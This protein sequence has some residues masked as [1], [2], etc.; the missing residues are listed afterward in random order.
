MYV[1]SELFVVANKAKLNC[2]LIPC[3]DW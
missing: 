1:Y 3:V 2:R